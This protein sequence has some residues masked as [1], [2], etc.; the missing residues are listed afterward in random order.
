MFES[1]NF[2][3]GFLFLPTATEKPDVPSDAALFG[4]D[5][6]FENHERDVRL[7]T[8]G[9]P[10]LDEDIRSA[11]YK[12][13]NEK[14]EGFLLDLEQAARNAYPDYELGASRTLVLGA[15]AVSFS[16]AI[17]D[18]FLILSRTGFLGSDAP[19]LFPPH[20]TFP[21]NTQKFFFDV[22]YSDEFNLGLMSSIN[23][24]LGGKSAP[25]KRNA[26]TPH[27]RSKSFWKKYRRESTL[28]I[29]LSAK[30]E[31]LET[32]LLNLILRSLGGRAPAGVTR[33]GLHKSGL[34][35]TSI[36][37][38]A[39]SLG[40]KCLVQVLYF[41]VIDSCP[42]D[43]EAREILK[44]SL[45]R[46]ME[47]RSSLASFEKAIY[48][49]AHTYLPTSLFE[50]IGGTNVERR[51]RNFDHIVT[52]S[53]HW[54]DDS[55]KAYVA[56]ERA[57]GAHLT[58]V[59]HGGTFHVED[60]VYEFE[61]NSGDFYVPGAR[62]GTEKGS[63]TTDLPIFKFFNPKPVRQ[64]PSRN[65]IVV[66]YEGNKWANRASA[67]PISYR[68]MHLA[69]QIEEVVENLSEEVRQRTILKAPARDPQ[70]AALSA[71]YER[72]SL[73][74]EGMVRTPLRKALKRSRI[75]LCCYPETAFGEAMG[76][77]RP[78]LLL[79]NLNVYNLHPASKEIFRRLL[80][81]RIAF[82]S[83][84]QVAAHINL[85]WPDPGYWWNSA[86]VLSARGLFMNFLNIHDSDGVSNWVEFLGGVNSG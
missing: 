26:E 38:L 29:F 54:L 41:P 66:I 10:W 34:S 24:S 58:I 44:S 70:W 79:V 74:T 59:E 19:F 61:R 36:V 7:V 57:A 73:T 23:Q 49:L 11:S 39:L 2:A 30:I 47:S 15:W 71:I 12:R 6:E 51:E 82:T 33:I 28:R 35:R 63:G 86:E 45:M 16:S 72:I 52:S 14:L 3:S 37:K 21:E 17:V 50:R 53:G 31:Y 80:D 56:T 18:R 60:H 85:I 81:A 84:Q 64:G 27:V 20:N 8:I 42:P 83:P 78:T 32:L 62:L 67:Q 46:N 76:C 1:N 48:A 43:P 5:Y 40:R 77:G 75:T 9:Y 4:I 25:R 65:L 68:A 69:G 22:S 13:I 55:F